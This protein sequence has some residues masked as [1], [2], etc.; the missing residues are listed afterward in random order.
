MLQNAFKN[1]KIETIIEDRNSKYLY[2][3][4]TNKT[5]NGDFYKI[6]TI[7]INNPKYIRTAVILLDGTEEQLLKGILELTSVIS[8]TNPINTT[9]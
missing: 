9:Y 2:I 8:C 7:K 6:S 5:I 4:T 3:Y 1:I